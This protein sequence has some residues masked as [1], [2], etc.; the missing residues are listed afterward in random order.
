MPYAA[1]RQRH[2][3]GLL[4]YLTNTLLGVRGV[5]SLDVAVVVI[6][7]QCGVASLSAAWALIDCGTSQGPLPDVK[8]DQRFELHF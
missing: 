4:T 7:C 5:M 8:V 1:I 3:E 6:V 2:A